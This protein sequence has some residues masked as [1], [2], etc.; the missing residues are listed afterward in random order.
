MT[1]RGRSLYA[2]L[3]V[4]PDAS[5]ASIRDA[6]RTKARL[7]HPDSTSGSG[8]P[9]AMREL[10]EAWRVLGDPAKRQRYDERR[11]TESTVRIR[12][13]KRHWS[14]LD[15]AVDDEPEAYEDLDPGVPLDPARSRMLRFLTVGAVANAVGA[16]VLFGLAVLLQAGELASM[17][18]V[19]LGIS[20]ASFTMAPLYAMSRSGKKSDV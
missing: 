6:Y 5:A 20:I 14:P 18:V 10:N 7:V 16:G 8:S 1:E 2:V 15:H 19:V 12:H 9:E 13:Q 11:R 3:G 17:G 4:Q